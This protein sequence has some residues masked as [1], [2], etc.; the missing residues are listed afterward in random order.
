MGMDSWGSF[1]FGSFEPQQSARTP[2]LTVRCEYPASS[3]E[4]TCVSF[5]IS[6][7]YGIRS[8]REAHEWFVR[9]MQEHEEFEVETGSVG[10]MADAVLH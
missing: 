1:D 9:M 8:A 7:S 3:M 5:R 10:G 4:P 6:P 2:R